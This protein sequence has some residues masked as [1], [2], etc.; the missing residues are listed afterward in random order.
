MSGK[1]GGLNRIGLDVAVLHAIPRANS[2]ARMQPEAHSAG[3]FS[4]ANA[5]AKVFGEGHGNATSV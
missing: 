2:Y 3:D 1:T 5:F 4:A